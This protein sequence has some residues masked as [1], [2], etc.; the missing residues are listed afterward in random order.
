MVG[1]A[2]RRGL[3]AAAGELAVLV[4]EGDQPSQVDRDVVGLALVC[5]LYL[6]W[7]MFDGDQEHAKP[8]LRAASTRG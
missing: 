8:Q 6:S 1:F 5:V 3:V 7:G 2:S 4:A